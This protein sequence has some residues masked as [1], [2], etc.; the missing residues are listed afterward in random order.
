MK[1][2]MPLFKQL[3]GDILSI[4]TIEEE[5]KYIQ[6]L[7]IE[8]GM[9][10]DRVR[11][12]PNGDEYLL[13][14]E[15]DQRVTVVVK[16][17]DISLESYINANNPFL[18]VCKHAS[19][20]SMFLPRFLEFPDLFA[21]PHPL[22]VSRILSEKAAVLI[23]T[24]HSVLYSNPNED[25]IDWLLSTNQMGKKYVY[26]MSENSNPRMLDEV[27]KLMID[28]NL[29]DLNLSR[30]IYHHTYPPMIC[31]L[32]LENVEYLTVPA[33]IPECALTKEL[34]KCHWKYVHV[35][36]GVA[37][38]RDRE[39]IGRFVHEVLQPWYEKEKNKRSP[40]YGVWSNLWLN[41]SDVLVDW[42]IA[43]PDVLQFDNIQYFAEN[44]NPKA[45]E[46]VI[47]HKIRKFEHLV[48][49]PS[50]KM[51]EF[52]LNK[53]PPDSVDFAG[54]PKYKRVST[55]DTFGE[56]FL[57]ALLRRGDVI[58]PTGLFQFLGE[59]DQVVFQI[60]L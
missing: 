43:C 34:V 49:N 46:F 60:E 56:E 57:I 18:R 51:I 12:V 3:N 4:E 55:N 2:S 35:T 1:F 48:K 13:F 20:L 40:R 38:F 32:F 44:P 30:E 9:R 5:K 41:P 14:V 16:A 28:N 17:T 23:H 15:D 39:L 37:S 58:T 33:V 26:E 6:L 25:I 45:I 24:R 11:I 59:S 7:S 8:L 54:Q 27:L 42:L 52:M 50:P 10:P 29:D 36:S 53:L 31:H 21:N 19:V 22:V 47:Q